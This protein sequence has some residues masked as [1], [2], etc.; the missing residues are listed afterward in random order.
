VISQQRISGGVGLVEA[1]AGELGHEIENLFDFLR[2]KLALRCAFDEAL[3]LFRHFFRVFFAHGATQQVGFAE[4]VS[5]EAVRN[6]HHLFLIHDHAQGFFKNF[7]QLRQFVLDA[8]ATVLAVDE[9]FDHSALNG[10]RAVERIQS[11]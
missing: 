6:L 8:L 3:A 11:S 1:V 4:R 9:I 2:R 10:T 5:G 7:F